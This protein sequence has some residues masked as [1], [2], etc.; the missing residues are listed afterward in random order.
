MNDKIG[1]Q[2]Y[3]VRP[4]DAEYDPGKCSQWVARFLAAECYRW[5]KSTGLSQEDQASLV[6]KAEHLLPI[7]V[8][9]ADWVNDRIV[10]QTA[11]LGAGWDFTED[12]G[13]VPQ[14][15]GRLQV[16]VLDKKFLWV[17]ANNCEG[18]LWGLYNNIWLRAVHDFDHVLQEL[19]MSV[20]DEIRLGLL[21]A[22]MLHQYVLANSGN[23][24]LA[25]K[26]ALLLA[27]DLAGQAFYYALSGGG[28]VPDQRAFAES[29]LRHGVLTGARMYWEGVRNG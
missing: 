21:E 28:F 25:A 18:T 4:K 7:V 12:E 10:E 1:I 3:G 26:C 9:V 6:L 14:G 24:V 29:C 17:S 15:Y 8:N 13:L 23:R 11:L 2:P 16:A 20:D 22:S 27:I 5:G 19:S